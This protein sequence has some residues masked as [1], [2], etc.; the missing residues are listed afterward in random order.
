[1]LPTMPKM[2][3]PMTTI[4]MKFSAFVFLL[5]ISSFLFSQ[6]KDFQ[7]WYTFEF[8]YDASEKLRLSIEEELR[9]RENSAIFDRNQLDIGGSY[10]ITGAFSG[11]L[12]YHMVTD[13]SG[14][15][16]Y[17]TFHRFYADGEYEYKPRR[18]EITARLRLSTDAEESGGLSDIFSEG[19]HREKFTVRY[20]IRKTSFT[21]YVAGELYFPLRTYEHYLQKYRLFAGFTYRLADAHRIGLSFM[22]QHR[23]TT[24]VPRFE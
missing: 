23:L 18:F 9:F 2:Q 14:N 6:E 3:Y 1:M 19:I 13:H 20:N 11:G 17:E 8:A 12:F 10:H 16:N 7:S 4:S 15:G 5:F 22:R 24:S 21:P